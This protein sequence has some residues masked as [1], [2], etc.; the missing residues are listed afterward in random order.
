[1][2]VVGIEKHW[3]IGLGLVM[4]GLLMDNVTL[5]LVKDLYNYILLNSFF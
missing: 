1:M 2:K 5:L 3:V 4:M